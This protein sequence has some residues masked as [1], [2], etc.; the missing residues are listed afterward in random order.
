MM[1]MNKF[2]IIADGKYENIFYTGKT[3]KYWSGNIMKAQAFN[4]IDAAN[5]VASRF[6]HNNAR[7]VEILVKD[8]A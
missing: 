1:N 6:R 7:V 8:V 2:V 5:R 4:S 3:D